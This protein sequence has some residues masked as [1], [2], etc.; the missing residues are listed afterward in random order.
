MVSGNG[1]C[2]AA[3]SSLDVEGRGSLGETLLLA[4]DFLGFLVA[5]ALAAAAGILGTV[6]GST[7]NAEAAAG[8][9]GGTLCLGE[10][11]PR[12][13]LGD[14]ECLLRLLG[15]AHFP[16]VAAAGTVFGIHPCELAAGGASCNTD[17]GGPCALGNEVKSCPDTSPSIG[18]SETS[19]SSS[20]K[21]H[22]FLRGAPEDS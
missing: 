11:S 6:R 17:T 7:V 15:M 5:V 4:A 2:A 21:C 16:L 1:C 3:V 18:G 10:E 8:C 19:G 9:G 20:A 14:L 12:G 13:F 22:A